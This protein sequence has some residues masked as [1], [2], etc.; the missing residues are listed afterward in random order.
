M[1]ALRITVWL[2]LV[3]FA[4]SGPAAAQ[5][6]SGTMEV[7]SRPGGEELRIALVIGNE[8]YP[9][10]AL[11]NPVND[12]RLIAATLN[13]VGFAVT[14][15]IDADQRTM[16]AALA[17]FGEQLDLA[18]ENAIGLFYYA[19]HG[20]QVGG[21]NYLLPVD[22]NIHTEAQ[23]DVYGVS[24]QNVLRQMEFARNRLNIVILDACR[25]N[26][27]KRSFR[28]AARGLAQ[29]QA[30]K[31][32]LLAF[33]TAPGS[34]AA[35]GKGKNS[36]YALALS[37][38]MKAPGAEVLDL[39]RDVR[40]KVGR[41]TGDEQV[42]WF[43]SSLDGRFYFTAAAAPAGAP[44]GGPPAV[45]NEAVFW[46]SIAGSRN[47]A[48]FE[49]YLAQFPT[50]TFAALA[51]NRL[52]VLRG[53]PASGARAGDHQIA[54]G[55]WPEKTGTTAPER[56]ET[57]GTFRECPDCPRMVVVPSGAFRMGDLTG[58]GQRDETPVRTVR[59]PRRFAVGVFEVTA[60]EF[61]AFVRATGRSTG[62]SCYASS[63]YDRPERRSWRDPGFAQSDRQPAVC[64]SWEDARAYVG[65][66]SRKTGKPYR[67]LS[68]SEWEYVAR[69]GGAGKYH[70]GS[71]EADLC[72][73]AN[74]A[75]RT[76]APYN[77]AANTRCSDGYRWTAPVGSFAANAF[78]L[79]DVHGNVREWV[80]D[81]WRYRDY[82]GAPSD[83]SAVTSDRDC[84]RRTMRGGSWEDGA[85]NLRAA[86]R[87][88]NI[89][90]LRDVFT[91]FRVARTLEGAVK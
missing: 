87:T 35:D 4:W 73:Y 19:G 39:F 52:A 11:R 23:V 63:S 62:V 84:A 17:K 13:E 28:S 40:I 1:S 43:Q 37:E 26:P 31:G 64:V 91:G 10:G 34:V 15:L 20:V 86:R 75:D 6:A 18:G 54:V 69:A 67:L 82:R 12:A 33:A 47:P 21:H 74:G 27:F 83:G 81:C 79:H 61:A 88:G 8:S 9:K 25:D 45:S 48:D 56:Q 55:S 76:M 7:W 66:L 78:G 59:I 42:P 90:G 68:E 70:F 22:A 72:R 58:G 89:A 46:Q 57:G 60:G 5:G 3:A 80:A 32:S 44:R 2:A 14:T 71:S 50:G 41:T 36:P 29:M 85:R 51:R 24:A 16:K 65:W 77:S 49:A 53:A 38:M 30:P